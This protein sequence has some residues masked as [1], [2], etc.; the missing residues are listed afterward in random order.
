MDH[1]KHFKW[2]M[3]G[4]YLFYHALLI[5]ELQI[6]CSYIFKFTCS[7]DPTQPIRNFIDL[8]VLEC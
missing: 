4:F 1:M 5:S 8:Y 7:W 6:N 2:G 3:I